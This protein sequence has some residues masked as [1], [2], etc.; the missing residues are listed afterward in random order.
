MIGSLTDSTGVMEA[1]KGLEASRHTQRRAGKD[2]LAAH[3]AR[4][5]TQHNLEEN[6]KAA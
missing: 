2:A 3:S 1:A 5:A 6:V 4:H